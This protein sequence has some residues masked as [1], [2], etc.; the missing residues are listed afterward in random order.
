MLLATK[1]Q[2]FKAKKRKHYCNL[3]SRFSEI[4]RISLLLVTELNPKLLPVYLQA[5]T[6]WISDQIGI[7]IT[8]DILCSL[9]L[10]PKIAWDILTMQIKLALLFRDNS[11][12]A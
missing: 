3:I 11:G 10:K 7:V 4:Q 2:I 12:A 6:V 9:Y 1:F 8:V 5:W